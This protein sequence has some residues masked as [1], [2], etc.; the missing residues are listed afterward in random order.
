MLVECVRRIEINVED[1]EDVYV[2]E[3]DGWCIVS[4]DDQDVVGSCEVCGCLFVEGDRY[5][6]YE[7]GVL[8]CTKTCSCEPTR[9]GWSE[10]EHEYLSRLR[11]NLP[12]DENGLERPWCWRDIAS[13]MN[14]KFHTN[15]SSESCRKAYW[16]L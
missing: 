12:T 1:W 9:K 14:K 6:E 10:E 3:D 15:R 2:L 16:R 8:T 5:D 4:V 11:D 7:D 13:K